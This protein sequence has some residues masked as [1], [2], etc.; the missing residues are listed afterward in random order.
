MSIVLKGSALQARARELSIPGRSR[1]SADELRA[2]V[3]FHGKG[4][5][6]P[7][8]GT[9]DPIRVYCHACDTALADNGDCWVCVASAISA[10]VPPQVDPQGGNLQ[11]KII[12][13]K[14][15]RARNGKRK[16]S[17]HKRNR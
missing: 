12:S 4:Y 10:P 15:F 14:P 5:V 6:V 9:G 11:V 7:G 8:V 13:V 16:P 3:E 17:I 2:A 1:M